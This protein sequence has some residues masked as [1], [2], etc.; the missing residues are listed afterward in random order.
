VLHTVVLPVPF[1]SSLPR[2]ELAVLLLLLLLVLSAG[3]ACAPLTTVERAYGGRVVDGDAIEPQ[4]YAAFLRG[5]L[6][7]ADGDLPGALAA[8]EH[9]A[10]LDPGSAEIWTRVG[11]ARC[12]L[13]PRDPRADAAFARAID[14]DSTSA[15][16]FAARA[17][18]LLARGDVPGA[19]A[20]A[21]RAV[22][23]D[24][25]VDGA[26]VLLAGTAP[27]GE[28]AT[29]RA[30]L[31][32]LTVTAREPLVAWDA[33]AS[34]ARSR[35]DVVLW[36]CALRE[37]V[38]I[39]PA[40]RDDVA[41]AAEELAGA[42][43]TSE[44]RGVAAAAA[45]AGETPLHGEHAL[46]ARLAI[47][48]A[49]ARGDAGSVERRATRVRVSLD[50]A[51]GRELAL[52][53][54]QG[55]PSAVGARL[56]LAATSRDVASAAYQAGSTVSTAASTASTASVASA[57]SGAPAGAAFVAFGV[58]LLRATSPERARAA[59]AAIGHAGILAGDERV[60][61]PA[62]ELVSRGALPVDDLPPDGVVELSAR[63]AGPLPGALVAWAAPDARAL[64]ARH[65][66]LAL[67]LV[68]PEG[69]HAQALGLR[70]EDSALSDPVVAAA[71]AL[72]RLAAGRGSAA[73]ALLA[74]D[75]GDP[76]L[77]A[78]ALHVAERAGE[79]DVAR[80]ARD[81]LSVL[82]GEASPTL[83]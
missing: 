25:A 17:R 64:D 40:R 10:R 45:D 4:A 2:P 12:R 33:L 31:V 39:A 19:R 38:R 18:C 78:T 50:E 76:L 27:P 72:V 32:G 9:A 3:V 56:V 34:W 48:E 29:T 66:Y 51:A 26:N 75:P 23:L 28:D 5:T 15:R 16:A 24:P 59:L 43:R 63:R 81:T 71:A 62:V 44:A 14:R 22:A 80:R 74:R 54:A 1:W 69:P 53:L 67:A 70:L 35:G 65:E 49:I 46:A 58:A 6:A 52:A 41:R 42:G 11:D 30:V 37:S 21:G 36:A 57:V 83:E 7:E 8:H 68:Q 60:V 61:R 77:V 82:E 73:G 13:D 79:R 55:S 20:A 47:D